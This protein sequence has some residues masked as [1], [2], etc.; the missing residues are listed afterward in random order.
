MGNRLRIFLL[1]CLA[2]LPVSAIALRA[3]IALS[4]VD[5]AAFSSRPSFA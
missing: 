4:G 1:R 3:V 5:T 2:I